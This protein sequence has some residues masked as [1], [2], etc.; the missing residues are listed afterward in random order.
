MNTLV[1]KE[2]KDFNVGKILN[3]VDSEKVA[4]ILEGDYNTVFLRKSFLCKFN[5]L[6]DISVCGSALNYL[7]GRES[8][9]VTQP[10]TSFNI[11]TPRFEGNR[12]KDWRWRST[13]Q[14]VPV[15]LD[16]ILVAKMYRFEDIEVRIHT[17]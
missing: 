8:F 10:R 12:L 16:E 7:W 13:N 5:E 9:D 15:I 1:F 2:I 3:Q 11:H 4:V 17:L 6:M 14:A